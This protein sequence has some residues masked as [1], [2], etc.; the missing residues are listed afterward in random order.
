MHLLKMAPLV[1]PVMHRC[2]VDFHAFF[3]PNRLL[4]ENFEKFQ[5]Y[6][7]LNDIPVHPY[8][9]AGNIDCNPDLKIEAGSLM[10]YLDVPTTNTN[11]S[12]FNTD[13]PLRNLNALIPAAYLK[14]YD[15][16]YR[17]QNLQSELFSAPMTDGDI[18]YNSWTKP[19]GVS[20]FKKGSLLKRA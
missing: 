13:H 17:D 16:Y 19:K 20:M 4:W 5:A 14:I 10:D 6:D 15:D 12:T 11:L 9:D 3:V 7:T 1:T 8:I 18:S 2:K